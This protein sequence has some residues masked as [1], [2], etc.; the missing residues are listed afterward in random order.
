[1]LG[2]AATGAI[3]FVKP[4][5]SGAYETLPVQTYPIDAPVAVAVAPDWVEVRYLKTVLGT[6]VLGRTAKGWQHVDPA[7]LAPRPAPAADAVKALMTDAFVAN[8]ARYGHIASLDG[9]VATTDTG[10]TV[11]LDWNRLALSQRGP[12]TDRIDW[13]YRIHYL[14]WTGVAALDRVLGLS[15]LALVV[16]LSLLGLRLWFRTV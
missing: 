8:P 9:L 4:G 7:T 1:M 2:W 10:V 11:T 15:G 6:H 14:Q 13:F 16:A 12:D 5:Y 3:F